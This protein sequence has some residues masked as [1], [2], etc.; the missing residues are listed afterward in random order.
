MGNT[1]QDVWHVTILWRMT[2]EMGVFEWKNLLFFSLSWCVAIPVK[3]MQF[4]LLTISSHF[5]VCI[6]NAVWEYRTNFSY[7]CLLRP[8]PLLQSHYDF[9]MIYVC[10]FLEKLSVSR[11]M[12]LVTNTIS[13]MLV[14]TFSLRSPQCFSEMDL[15]TIEESR[16][17]DNDNRWSFHQHSHHVDQLYRLPT[18]L[19]FHSR[20]NGWQ[21]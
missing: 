17:Q 7:S 21:H 6:R 11:V 4:W 8:L 5:N 20:W 9:P 16:G 3:T 10:F 14:A 2:H 15:C 12:A 1:A 19:I 13:R 18:K